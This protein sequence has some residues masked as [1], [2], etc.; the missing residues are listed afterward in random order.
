MYARAYFFV[1]ALTTIILDHS[2]FIHSFIMTVHRPSLITITINHQSPSPASF[3]IHFHPFPNGS[4]RNSNR[5]VHKHP[6]RIPY[7]PTLHEL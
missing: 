5:I 3:I 1:F 2:S 7:I 4:N 6:L